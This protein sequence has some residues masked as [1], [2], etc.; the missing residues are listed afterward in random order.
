[1]PTR[2]SRPC[3]P[4]LGAAV[5]LGGIALIVPSLRTRVKDAL[6]QA[7][8]ALR[9]LRSPRKLAQL[10]GGNLM[11]QLLFAL[12]LGVCVRA[13][14]LHVP[15]SSLILIN[16]AVSLFAG[17]LPVPGGVGVSEAGIS[18]GLTRA[19]IPAETAFA[20]ALCYRFVTFYL[21]PIWGYQSYRWLAS[22]KYL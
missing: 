19:G 22:H 18:L 7:H 5:W 15:L 2:P 10:F 11:S 8:E 3:L 13:F 16:S 12:T 14:G 9:V 17:L 1:M 20:V 6:R 4:L 21:P